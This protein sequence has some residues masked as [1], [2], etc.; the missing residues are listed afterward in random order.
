MALTITHAK[1]NDIPDWTQAELDAQIALGNFPPGTLLADITLPSDWN[2]NHA[3]AGSIAWGEITGTL[4]NQTDLQ[5]ALNAKGDVTGPSSSTDNAIVRFD[6]STG[7]IIQDYTS[8]AP[9]IG[10][11]GIAAFNNNVTIAG[12]EVITSTSASAFVVGP[13][14]ATNPALLIDNSQA[15]GNTGW[16]ITSGAGTRTTIQVISPNGNENGDILA[17]A[18]GALRVGTSGNG[19]TFNV[20]LGTTNYMTVTNSLTTISTTSVSLPTVTVGV[21]NGSVIG[22]AYGGAG[23][24]NGILK[25]NGSGTVSAAS[26]GTDYTNASFSTISVS[27]Q[28]DVVADSAADTL[29]L[30][31]GSNITI[32]TNA[33]TDAITI[34]ASGSVGSAFTDITS[35]TNTTAAMVV[36]TGASLD[37]SGSGTINATSVVAANEATDTTCFPLFVTAATGTLGPKTNTGLAYNSNTSAVTITSSSATALA[38]GQNGTTNPAFV[39]NS[40]TGSSVAGL[41]VSSSATGNGPILAP[42]GASDEPLTITTRGSN[43]SL[44]LGTAGA[45]GT[46][47]LQPNTTTRYTFSPVT[48]TFSPTTNSSATT[49]S[50]RFVVTAAADTSLTA[51]TE[52]PWV[53]FNGSATRQHGSNTAI[54]TQRD[55]RI[56][57][58]SHSYASSG[59]VITNLGVLSLSWGNAGTNTTVTHNAALYIPTQALTGTITTAY[60]IRVAAPSGGS[61]NYAISATDASQFGTIDFGNNT[62]TT[63]SRSAAGVIAVEGVDVPTISSTNT[64]TNK[65]ITKRVLTTNAPGATPTLNTDNYDVANF[66]GLN[67]AITSMTTNLSGTP[68]AFQP[69]IIAFTDNGTAR[70]ITWGASF[71][72]STVALPTTTVIS[73]LLTV[74]FFWN[75]VTSKWRCVAVA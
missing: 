61:T 14:G 18:S 75:S 4:S 21:W 40:S 1:T 10:D 47:Q 27:G 71:E 33:A 2:A 16:S 72:A 5:T 26:A 66:T 50:G 17:K 62:D 23:T 8:N 48:A 30:V 58:S 3:L 20:R 22:S 6:G 49:G 70:S 19:G 52:A 69:L 46:I 34:A 51:G 28:S 55:F 12:T 56:L 32:T 15:S 11:T 74:G 73:T 31:A 57:G 45:N 44:L 39:V 59:G 68:T 53:Y 67:A 25:A 38:V 24:V 65:R 63:V 29:T 43:G 41:S 13:N 60:A 42:I 54:T 36:G 7:K 35:G 9:T 37:V 64:L